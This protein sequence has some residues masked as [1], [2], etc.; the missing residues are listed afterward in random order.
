VKLGRIANQ[1]LDSFIHD[2]RPPVVHDSELIVLSAVGSSGKPVGT[3]VNWANHPETLGSKNTEVTADYPGYF[4]K[5]L[6]RRLGG[7]AVL[8]NGA[9]GGMQSPLG[10][11]IED[12]K[13][14]KPCDEES[15]RKAEVLGTE[16]AAM[17]AD[18]VTS[19]KPSAIDKIEFREEAVDVPVTNKLFRVAATAGIF[20]HRRA[21][22]ANGTM[23]TRVGMFRLSAGAEP[24]LEAALVPG[25]LYPE[26]SVGGVRRYYGADFP[27]AEI[28]P[29]V[30][31]MMTAPFR[32]LIGLA[33]DEIGYLIPKAEWDE[34][35]PYLEDAPKPWY[36][37]ISSVG[38]D[39]APHVIEAIEDL[40]VPEEEQSDK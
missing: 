12:P 11:Q 16:V 31:S 39:A 8:V 15:F 28:E 29:A 4:Y 35:P 23:E 30:K 5:E 20:K 37:E 9:I 1:E 32:M 38:P 17:A 36:G 19:A 34:K 24:L 21:I 14:G 2:D 6:E 33:D 10:A 27:A 40:L 25:E 26:L 18:A 13:T 7:V 22:G 3:L